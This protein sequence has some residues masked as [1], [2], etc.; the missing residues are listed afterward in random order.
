MS[1]VAGTPVVVVDSVTKSYENGKIPV[2]RGVSFSVKPG[3]MLALW[4][5]SGSGK[6]TLLHML[7]GLDTPDSGTLR[8][9]DLDATCERARLRLRREFT[10]YVFQL[11]NLIPDLTLWENATLPLAASGRRTEADFAH[12]RSLIESVG[13]GHRL[14]HRMQDLSG[15]E[16]QRTAIVRALASR[17]RVLLADEPTGALD[18][19]TG[20]TVFSLMRELARREG[21]AVVLATHERRFA[22]ACDRVLR[23]RDGQAVEERL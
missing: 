23:V 6:S 22:S 20:D 14:A 7:G 15:G 21:A 17:P 18:E 8:V 10:G 9:C 19:A 11:H 12:V 4:G 2:L 3:E 13:L 1:D 5:A 16:R